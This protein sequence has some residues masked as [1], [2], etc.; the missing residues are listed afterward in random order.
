MTTRSF[1]PLSRDVHLY[2]PSPLHPQVPKLQWKVWIRK[3]II[4]EQTKIPLAPMGICDPGSAHAWLST[5]QP[6]DNPFK[7]KVTRESWHLVPCS[8]CNK[9]RPS[10]GLG[11]YPNKPKLF[12][13]ILISFPP[14]SFNLIK[15][16]ITPPKLKQGPLG[17]LISYCSAAFPWVSPPL[18]DSPNLS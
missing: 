4:R 11:S 6:Y 3:A 15:P 8:A 10:S 16:L 13:P 1:G 17:K 12:K 14:N 18:T 2:F 7:E 5:L 9:K